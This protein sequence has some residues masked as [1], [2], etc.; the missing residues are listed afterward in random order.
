M[1]GPTVEAGENPVK[2]IPVMV[3]GVEAEVHI[4]EVE[5][6]EGG[7][8]GGA[9]GAGGQLGNNGGNDNNY[10]RALYSQVVGMRRENQEQ[11]QQL[12]EEVIRL[13]NRN[14]Q[15]QQLINRSVRRIALQPVQRPRN[16]QPPGG[17]A[18]IEP[19]AGA[20]VLVANAA[21]LSRNPRTLY[22][23]WHEFE[24]GIGGRK[25][26][27]EFTA[28]ERGR[29]KYAYHRRKVVWDKIAEK[30]RAGWTANTA[31]D[32]I[33]NHYGRGTSVT[34]IINTMRR[35]RIGGVGL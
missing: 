2:K 22:L 29:A 34:I 23:L 33:Y 18:A 19:P 30:I 32:A 21:T 35:D 9:G 12:R 24:F 7:V 16:Q 5:P 4:D 20:G 26:A 31:I 15:Q 6:L 27:R 8:G 13:S 17:A 28:V 1:E 3:T 10:V 25:A 11:I 14:F